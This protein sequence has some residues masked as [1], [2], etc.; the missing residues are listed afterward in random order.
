MWLGIRVLRY[1]GTDLRR[2]TMQVMGPLSSCYTKTS[3]RAPGLFGCMKRNRIEGVSYNGNDNLSASPDIFRFF[4]L[5]IKLETD[6][7]YGSTNSTL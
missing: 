6:N 7:T 3:N 5:M 1:S 2:K 4:N